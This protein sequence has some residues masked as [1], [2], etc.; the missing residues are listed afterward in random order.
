MQ[1]FQN[2][3]TPGP[4][5]ATKSAPTVFCFICGRQ[6]GSKSIA[7]HE[8]QCLKKW[9]A[10]NEKLPK[11]KRRA[12]PVKPDAVIGNDGEVDAVATNEV[13]WKNSQ[14]LMVECEHCG[15]KFNEDRLSVHQRSCTAENPAKSVGRSR[16]KSQPKR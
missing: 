2:N 8:P 11:S 4:P 10:E 6:F 7:I 12:A 5:R 16:S 15:R 3:F 13:L 1:R 14:G 9:H